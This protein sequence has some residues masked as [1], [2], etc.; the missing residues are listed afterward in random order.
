MVVTFEE[1]KKL[2]KKDMKEPFFEMKDKFVKCNFLIPL[3]IT[4]LGSSCPDHVVSVWQESNSGA[5][6]HCRV[7]HDALLCQSAGTKFQCLSFNG[8]PLKMKKKIY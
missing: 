7:L 5:V 2:Y 1:Q 4:W 3:V 8:L 6:N